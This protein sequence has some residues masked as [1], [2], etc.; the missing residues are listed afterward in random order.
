MGT[1]RRFQKQQICICLEKNSEKKCHQLWWDILLEKKTLK[2]CRQNWRI[3]VPILTTEN[4]RINNITFIIVHSK[5]M[6]QNK[7]SFFALFFEAP[8]SFSMF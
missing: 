8:N 6:L 5:I 4:N 1:A 3:P 2:Q 7:K